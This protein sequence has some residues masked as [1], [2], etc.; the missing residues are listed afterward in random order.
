M[1]GW[2]GDDFTGA[3]DTLSALAQARM[4]ALLF[5]GVPA[6]RHLVAAGPL[7]AIGIAG[8]ARSMTPDA[9]RAELEPVGQ[10]FAATKV[11]V[12]HYKVCSTFDS[13]PTVGSIG[14]AIAT[15]RPYVANAFVPIVGGQPNIGRYCLYSHLFA[16][17]GTGGAVHRIDRHPTMSRH[18]V[19]P[20][21]EADLRRQLAAQG[22]PDVGAMHYPVY[23]RDDKAQDACLDAELARIAPGSG[24]ATRPVL[25]DVAHAAHLVPVGRMLWARAQQQRL[26]AVGGSSVVQ[27]FAACRP[28]D[29]VAADFVPPRMAAARGPVLVLSGSMSPV[30]ARQIEAATAY[31]RM[32]VDAARLTTEPGYME[33]LVERIATALGGQQ[34]VL[35]HVAAPRNPA[36]PAVGATAVAQATARLMAQVVRRMARSTPL[37]RVGIAGGDT[38]SRVAQALGLWGLSYATTVEPGVTL[39][40]AHSEEPSLDGLELMLKGGQM[41]AVDLF[42]RL[43]RG[44]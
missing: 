43:V 11:P 14:V 44:E 8:A 29:G 3:T 27:A 9:M 26:L 38:S 33:A 31:A 28:R 35:A 37:R 24:N 16:A 41:G 39:S 21:H 17:A 22:L 18:P 7:D 10:F 42:D 23:D 12:L 20:M 13:A 4:R 40:L 6:P 19:T 36:V 25:F 1:L 32:P 2:Y 30:T 5:M 15:L 34:N